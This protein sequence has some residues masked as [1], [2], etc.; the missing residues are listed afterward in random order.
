[1]FGPREG[2][3]Q[4][5]PTASTVGAGPLAPTASGLAYAFVGGSASLGGLALSQP[6]GLA[7]FGPGDY[8][9]TVNG[10]PVAS[11]KVLGTC[12]AGSFLCLANN[13]FRA[14]VT[15]KNAGIATPARAV[16]LSGDTGYFYFLDPANVELVVKVLDGR[17]L[18]GSFWVFY[19]ALSNLEYTLTIT[20]TVTGAVK[21]YANPSGRF[22]STGDTTAFPAPAS[23]LAATAVAGAEEAMSAMEVISSAATACVP[24]PTALCLAGSRFRVELS[25]KNAG[26]TNTGFAVPLS[27][28]TGYFYFLSPSN[29]EVVIKV[30]DARTFNNSFWVFY[31]ALS[32]L[33]YTLTVT[34][35]QTGRVKTYHNPNGTFA[36]QG[37][38]TALPGP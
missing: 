18:N 24:G 22:A 32:N 25:W 28:D 7:E 1:V 2:A 14:E 27:G 16:S 3:L 6:D 33:E 23:S 13:R 4:A 38:T 17:T 20:D 36:S 12:T 5:V 8:S 15:W 30:L 11:A 31:G 19:G 10:T 26:Q 9:L 29:V 35:T 37:D 21:V 34:D